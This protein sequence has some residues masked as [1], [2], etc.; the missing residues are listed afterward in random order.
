MASNET[1]APTWKTQ[2]VP[3]HIAIAHQ[4]LVAHAPS[5]DG[6]IELRE[7]PPEI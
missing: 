7:G 3:T 1:H 5:K 6:S 4:H 2:L